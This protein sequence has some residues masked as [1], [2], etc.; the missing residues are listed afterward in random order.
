M[1]TW[2]TR[3][4]NTL[5][6]DNEL[7]SLIRIMWAVAQTSQCKTFR[8]CVLTLSINPYELAGMIDSEPKLPHPDDW[9]A[10]LTAERMAKFE[11]NKLNNFIE[12]SRLE[13]L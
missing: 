11:A 12:S 2:V 1:N 8:R 5:C 4:N 6:N 7:F 10:G 9:F 13:G 3:Y